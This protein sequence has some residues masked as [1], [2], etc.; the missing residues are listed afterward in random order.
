MERIG[1]KVEIIKYTDWNRMNKVEK[2]KYI[3]NLVS[4][5]KD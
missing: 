1:Y 4:L 3:D 5:K 2:D